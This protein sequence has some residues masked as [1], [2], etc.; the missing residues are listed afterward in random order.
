[1]SDPSIWREHGMPLLRPLGSGP[2][3]GCTVAVKDL[4]ALAVAGS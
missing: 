3:D 1:M 4:F 2:L